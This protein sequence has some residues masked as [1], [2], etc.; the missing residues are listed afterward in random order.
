MNKQK[1]L[2]DIKDIKNIMDRSTKFISLSG[3][4][5]ISAGILALIASYIAYRLVYFDQ[6][7]LVDRI[8]VINYKTLIQLLLVAIATKFLAILLGIFFTSKKAKKS[9]QKMWDPQ[10][11]RFYIN[12]LIPLITGGLLCLALL[13]RGYVSLV[14][15]LTLIFYGL[16]L[17]NASNHSIS[18]I[19]S[20]G[21]IEIILGLIAVCFVGYGLIFWAIGFGVMHIIYGIVMHYKYGS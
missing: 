5:G 19:R 20:L 13:L 6:N 10:A 9:G 1:Y 11:R 12:L 3:L 15:P 16:G 4:S 21:I 7:Y 2:D 14:A 17:V 18:D 8:A